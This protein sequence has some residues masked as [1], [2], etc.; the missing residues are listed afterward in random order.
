[1]DTL[2][3]IIKVW[4]II[5]VIFMGMATLILAFYKQKILTKQVDSLFKKN[6]ELEKKF[7]S[8]ITELKKEF[9]AKLYGAD[10]QTVYM[11]REGCK[12]CRDEC[13]VARAKE[14][15]IIL[16]TLRRL[17]TKFDKHIERS[18]DDRIRV[19]SKNSC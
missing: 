7:E 5:V 17:E 3:M 13:Q 1:M 9:N 19:T 12:A 14:F 16:D 6:R 10:G 18:C 4:P 11:P 15:D 8:E 2:D